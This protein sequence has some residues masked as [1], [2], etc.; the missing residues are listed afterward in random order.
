MPQPGRQPDDR[1]RFKRTLDSVLAGSTARE[2]WKRSKTQ[3][4][5]GMV[6]R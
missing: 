4:E 6:L 2:H 1:K 3:Q 5:A